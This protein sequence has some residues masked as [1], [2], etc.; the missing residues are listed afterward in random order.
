METISSSRIIRT[1]ICGSRELLPV[2][3]EEY[4]FKSSEVLYKMSEKK[5][6][7]ALDRYVA[8][9]K[10]SIDRIE[11][12]FPTPIAYY[13]YQ[14]TNNYRNDH[15]RLDLLKSCWESVVFFL[16][17]LTV[18][19]ARHRKLDLKSLGIKWPK[20]W[21]D[22]LF[23]K[24]SIIEN[25]LDYVTKTGISF[26]CSSIIPI[27]TLNLIKKLNQER[28]GFEH[29]AAK[30]SAQQKALYYVL[31]PQLELILRQLIKLENV[32]SS[33]ITMRRHLFTRDAKCSMAVHLMGRR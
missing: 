21:S 32:L 11:D 19:E 24:I 8:D 31:Y 33:D 1:S 10:V 28:N 14:A 5:Y 16:Y 26:D 23:D 25:I 22:K 9:A 18:G 29:A 17:G 20:Y 4:E 15:H 7:A 27:A 13:F 12:K 30:T 2:Q 6:S 3:I